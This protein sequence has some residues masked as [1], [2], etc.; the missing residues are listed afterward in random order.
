[1]AK[2]LVGCR[3]ELAIVEHPLGIACLQNSQEVPPASREDD[4]TDR[5]PSIAEAML[6]LRVRSVTLDG[7][8]VCCDGRGV[9]DFDRL[10]SAMARLGSRDVV[11][12]AFDLLEL[13]GEDLRPHPWDTRRA[14]LAGLL[15]K[16]GPGIRL[17]EHLE[18][19]DG[20][21]VLA[22]ACRMGLEGIVAKRRDR[23]YRS[24]RCLDWIK[25]K[26]PSAP[27]ASRH[28]EYWNEAMPATAP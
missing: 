22:H 7:E 24:G 25:V 16:V 27:S 4:W 10:R 5:V 28:L 3:E 11:L 19:A 26:N 18:G 8:A 23:P 2:L 9:T 1:V 15:R 12:F 6:R 21:T 20:T 13:N 14:T 17:S